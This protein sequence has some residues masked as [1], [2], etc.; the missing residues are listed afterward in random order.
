M[1]W[2]LI[3]TW[4]SIFT[5]TK[6]TKTLDWST[7]ID[8]LEE[9]IK[10]KIKNK[11][12]WQE[13]WVEIMV[14]FIPSSPTPFPSFL[15]LQF[16][17]GNQMPRERGW[18][19]IITRLSSIL[20]TP[21]SQKSSIQETFKESNPVHVSLKTRRVGVWK[22]APTPV[23]LSCPVLVCSTE[24]MTDSFLSF[25]SLYFY[26]KSS[27]PSTSLEKQRKELHRNSAGK[28]KHSFPFFSSLLFR[29][30]I[31]I[32]RSISSISCFDH[33]TGICDTKTRI[34]VLFKMTR[35]RM[36]WGMFFGRNAL[37]EPVDHV[38]MSWNMSPNSFERIVPL[39]L[40]T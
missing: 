38:N 25:L 26:A 20:R 14:W 10:R 28:K 8:E 13:T 15:S 33:E 4:S 39:P 34:K 30:R 36:D 40:Q 29:S 37:Q 3:G 27:F 22:T 11:K 6:T 32:T 31:I 35:K 12:E 7:F 17:Q 16:F 23:S 9:E 24:R 18:K 2:T 21:A 5:P 1:G 19:G